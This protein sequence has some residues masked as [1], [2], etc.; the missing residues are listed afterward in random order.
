[1]NKRVFK[2]D[3]AAKAAEKVALAEIEKLDQLFN[4]AGWDSTS[5]L[6]RAI[7]I[8]YIKARELGMLDA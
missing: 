3:E 7:L 1:M 2:N 8:T 6:E 4:K 5:K